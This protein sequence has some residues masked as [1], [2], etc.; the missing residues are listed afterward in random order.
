MSSSFPI[1]DLIPKKETKV[2][3][4]LEKYPEYNGKDII[5]GILDTGV[6]PGAAGLWTNPDGTSKLIGVVDCTGSGD[7]DVS[8]EREAVLEDDGW[9]VE[10]L[11]GKTLTLPKEW[12]L[13]P[14]PNAKKDEPKEEEGSESKDTEGTKDDS[15]AKKDGDDGGDDAN[16]V[17]QKV[18]LGWKRAYE[19]FPSRLEHRVKE[20]RKKELHK[21]LGPKIAAARQELSEWTAKYAGNKPTPD[22]VKTKEDLEAK[23]AVLQQD[24]EDPGP[25]YD[26]VVFWDGTTYRAALDV[27]ED[28]KLELALAP[29]GEERQFGTFGTVDQYNYAVNMY[30]DGKVLSIVGDAGAHATHVAGIAAASYNDEQLASGVAPGAKIVSFKIGDSRV[31]SMETG[32]ALCRAMIEAVKW[33]CDVI[34]LSYGEGILLPNTGRIVRLAHDLVYHHNIVFVSSAGNNGPALTTVGAPGGTSTPTLGIAAYVSPAMMKADYSMMDKANTN[35]KSTEPKVGTTYTWSSVGPTPDG[36]NGVDLTA[37][38]GAIT[39]VPNWTLQ[40]K[41]LMNGTSMSSP[42]ATGCIALLLSACKALGILVTPSRLRKALQNT[43]L[44]MTNLNTLQQGWGMI[45]VDKAF[46]YLQAHKDCE[47]EDVRKWALHG[48]GSKRAREKSNSPLF[49]VSLCLAASF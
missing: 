7:I 12:N 49:C 17:K 2:D 48:M 39:S 35:G 36:E 18:R 6:D 34:N 14:F 16:K 24:A 29:F 30:N 41:Q 40:K 38:G 22:Q 20:H 4:F 44:V 23:L 31:G 45:Q 21:A 32:T 3:A 11:S 37:P 27:K 5:I 28:G 1:E 15:A 46:E 8:T 13:Q 9:K 33:K 42:L 10:G 47:T 25:I 19:L 26:C 43:A